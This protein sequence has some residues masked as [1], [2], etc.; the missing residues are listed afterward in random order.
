MNLLNFRRSWATQLSTLAALAALQHS[1]SAGSVVRLFYDGISTTSSSVATRNGVSTLTNAPTFPDSPS[2]REQLDDFS[3]LA[4]QPLRAGLQGKDN[5]GADYGSFIRGYLE[6]PATGQYL[7]NIASDNG[8]ELYLST[9]YQEANRRLIAFELESGAPLFGGPRQD[10]RLSAPISLVRGQKYYFEVLHKQGAGGSYIQVGWQ[11]PDGV[12]EIVPALHL[13][14]Y[15]VDPFLGTGELGQAPVFNSRGLNAGNLPATVTVAEGDELLLQLD[16][17]AAQP[18]TFVWNRDGAVIPGE[19]LSFYRVARTPASLNGRKIQA[20]VSNAAGNLV[21]ATT[22]VTVTPDVKPP[23]VLAV[24]TGG[25]PNLLRVTFSEPVDVASAGRAANY[26]IRAVGGPLLPIQTVTVLPGDKTVEFAGTFGFRVG[27]DYQVTVQGIRDQAVVPNNLS[28]NPA[29]V[30]FVFSAPT[31]TTYSFNAGRPSGFSFF[32]TAEVIASG[33][34]DGSGYL[35][36]TDSTRNVNGAVVLTERRDVDQVRIRFKARISDGNSTTGLEVPGDGFGV[37]VAADL[38]LGTLG[39]PEEGFTPDVPGNRLSFAFDTHSDSSEDVP[40]ITV[41]LNNQVVT[42]VPAGT[43][44]IVLNGIPSIASVDGRWVD[45]DIDIRRNGL[46]TLRYDG[47]TVIN[48]LP[49]AFEVV[50]SAQIGFAART[51]NWF[52]THWFDDIN[53]NYGEGDIGDVAISP[54]SQLGGTFAEGSE[55]R[56]TV[57]PTGAGPFQYQ[58]FRNGAVLAGETRRVLRFPAIVG[59]GGNYSVQVKNAF[60][61]ITSAPSLVSIQPDSVAPQV[62]AISGIAGGVNRVRIHFDEPL[63]PLTA[64]DPTRYTS[65]LFRISDVLL[66][67]DGRSVTL[68]TTR[69]RVGITYPVTITGVRDRSAQGNVLN[70]TVNFVSELT[71]KDEV[72]AD[73]PVRYYRFEE[74]SGTVAFTQ[75]TSGDQQNTNA[76]YQNFP[77]LG[78]PSLVPSAAG[79]FATRFVRANTNYVAVPNGGDINDF[80]GPWAKKSYE[81]WF[82]AASTPTVAPAGANAATMQLTTTAG[83]WEEGGNLRSIAAYLW[84]NPAKL[85]ASEAELTFH[86][87]NDT[88]DG[89]GAPFGLRQ[90]PPVYVTHTVRT[91]T[92]YHVVAVMDG[93]TDSRDGELRL[94]VN[95]ELVSRSTNGVGQIYNHNGDVQIGRGTAR[96]HLDISANLGSFDGVIDEVSTYN[97]VLSEDRIRAHYLAGTGASLVATNPPTVVSSVNALGNPGQLTVVFN[98]P[99]SPAT[100]GNRA[101]YTIR[102]SGGQVLPIQTATLLD[103]LVTVKLSGAFGFVQGNTYTVAVQNVA[104]ILVPANVLVP[105]TVPFTFIT[106]G[107]VGLAAGSDLGDRTVGENGPVEFTAIPTGQPPFTY[108]WSRNGVVIPGASSSSLHFAAPLVSAGD[109]AVTVRNEF[110]A[111][112][113][114]TFRLTVRPDVTAPRLTGIRALSGSLNEVRLTFSEPLLPS[115]ATNPSTYAVTTVPTTGLAITS[116]TLSPDGREVRLRTT[117]QVNGQSNQITV[118]GLLDRAATPNA[119]S[120]SAGVVSGVSYRDEIIADG[121]VRYWTFGETNGTSFRT[122]VSKFD[123]AVENLVGTYLEGPVLGVPGLVPNLAGDTAVDFSSSSLSNRVSIPNGRDINAILGPWAKRTHVFTF[124]ADKLPRVT[125]TSNTVDG[126]TTLTTNKAAPALYAHDRIAFYLHATQEQDNPTQAQLVFRAHNTTS[127][128][129]GTPWGGTTLD[130]SKHVITTVQPGR[131]YHVVGVLDGSATGFDGQLRLYV[132]GQL[133]G[134][135]GGIG[136]IYKHPNTTPAFGQGSFRTHEGVAQNVDPTSTGY[137]ARFDGALDEFALVDRALSAARIAQLYA[138]AQVPPAPQTVI[139]QVSGFTEVRLEGG[140]LILS[141]EGPAKLQRA[142]SLGAAFTTVIGAESPYVVS[143]SGAEGYFRLQP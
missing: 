137:N 79:E 84:R 116:V 52:Q 140:G 130:T 16:A 135:V 35:R 89:P 85:N 28:P 76:V 29:T 67:A 58:W 54:D 80:R 131:V 124:R 10:Q 141:W 134:A 86:A 102:T 44:G 72:L 23:T 11:R 108:Q 5:S 47:V 88:P 3:A 113:S 61:E 133:A 121:A 98:Q 90:N 51:R 12:Q 129:P 65:P 34:H 45:V 109:Y 26:Q 32:G 138:F 42:N 75:T 1:A 73:N 120:V 87:Y 49:T 77:L 78:V 19:T 68:S 110:S 22:T 14:Q 15:P 122:L 20:Q 7:F 55:V 97:Q 60:S 91:N 125:I 27:V 9:D 104:D 40:S 143:P 114:P 57:L 17:I 70:T 13:A 8:S 37:N 119:L 24:E 142:T 93:R 64:S 53:V 41:L 95:G 21:S 31:G 69:Q 2:F 18:T 30:P 83:L 126:V 36:L 71:Y 127:E 128:G 46:L 92:I 123:T 106:A 56:L 66:S 81:F 100:A 48:Q 94:Y 33:S 50:N 6:A 4:G 39:Q 99:V 136:Q 132:D 105:A 38:P 115:S 59:G 111:F 82:N 118:T 62:A 63:D 43:N 101:N 25:N 96:T 117:P 112:T 74:T 107:P 139:P 103:D